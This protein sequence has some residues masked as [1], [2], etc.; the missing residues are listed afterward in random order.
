MIKYLQ[1]NNPNVP[2]LQEKLFPPLFRKLTLAKNYWWLYL[3]NFPGT[4]CIY[5]NQILTKKN[6]SIDHFIPWS[7]VTHDQ[8]WNLL[9]VITEVNSSKSDNIPSEIY[10]EKLLNLQ[11][12]AF[13]F[14]MKASIIGNKSLEDYSIIFNET[15]NDI[16]LFSKKKFTSILSDNIKPNIQIAINMGFSANWKFNL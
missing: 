2:N 16:S 9:P 11:Y 3:E 13:H 6:I 10:L 12:A 1:K 7:F 5:S 15:L 14:A 4:K 8:L